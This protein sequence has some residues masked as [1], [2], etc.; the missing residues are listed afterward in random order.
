MNWSIIADISLY[1]VLPTR[2]GTA[3]AIQI[4]ITNLLGNA[5]SP[6]IIGAVFDF[7]RSGI[8]NKVNF[9][10]GLKDPDVIVKTFVSYT[11]RCQAYTEFYV[12][13]YALAINVI[14]EIFGCVFFFI[15]AI[16][17]VEDK[18]RASDYLSSHFGEQLQDEGATAVTAIA[19]RQ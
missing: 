5:G 11:S 7:L 16:F 13:Q 15:A 2:R 12:M 9:C 18:R 19:A 17:V 14:A 1:V 6:Y 3:K 4:L 10:A 8:I